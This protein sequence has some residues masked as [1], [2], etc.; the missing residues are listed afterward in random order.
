ME[1][2]RKTHWTLAFDS[3]LYPKDTFAI[4]E[5]TFSRPHLDPC[6]QRPK[7]AVN[8]GSGISCFSERY[9]SREQT[10]RCGLIREGCCS[11]FFR[12]LRIKLLTVSV[13]GFKHVDKNHVGSQFKR[14]P[15]TTQNAI[16]L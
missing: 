2:K 3:D 8:L 4:P 6:L 11:E 9:R 10:T 5:Q 13:R 14:L 7:I 16:L 12:W 15:Q 1:M